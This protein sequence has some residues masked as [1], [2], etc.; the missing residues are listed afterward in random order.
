VTR[1]SRRYCNLRSP[2]GSADTLPSSAT[3]TVASLGIRVRL[4]PAD[5]DRAQ[6]LASLRASC[7]LLRADWERLIRQFLEIL[8]REDETHQAEHKPLASPEQ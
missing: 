1:A 8:D 2:V 3:P 6:Q 7:E 5:D 4:V